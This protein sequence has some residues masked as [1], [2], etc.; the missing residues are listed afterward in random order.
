VL[1]TDEERADEAKLALR[2]AY[3]QV[4]HLE[5]MRGAPVI[6]LTA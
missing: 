5:G 3:E 4:A 1:R 6:D 2:L